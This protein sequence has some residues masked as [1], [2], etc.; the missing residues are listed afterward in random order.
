MREKNRKSYRT[1]LENRKRIRIFCIENKHK[2]LENDKNRNIDFQN[3]LL[4]TLLK[5]L[6]GLERLLIHV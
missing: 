3:P 4:G 5:N 1:F 6:Q 2:A